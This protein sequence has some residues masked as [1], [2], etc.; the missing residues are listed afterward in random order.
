MITEPPAIVERAPM[1][2][3]ELRAGFD[4]SRE[5]WGALCDAAAA[6]WA[7]PHGWLDAHIWRE[8]G[9][10]PR[11]FRQERRL[12]GSPIFDA[13]GRPLTGVGLM[14]PTHP[15]VKGGLTDEQLFDP[16]TNIEVGARYM[17]SLIKKY[18]SDFPTVSAAYNAG[19]PRPDP[20]NPWNMHQTAGHVSSEVS[21]LN[22]L[23]AREK[24]IHEHEFAYLAS[25][26]S[27]QFID[28][29]PDVLT[30]QRSGDA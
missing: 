17:A 13:H 23:I 28:L 18:G 9:G 26:A 2:A 10:N 7:I 3:V 8:S 4:L 25:V 21:A 5:R 14:Q 29:R 16:S 6:R 24:T 12:D 19:S 27:S 30:P 11:A 1:L 22:Y 20:S 15:S